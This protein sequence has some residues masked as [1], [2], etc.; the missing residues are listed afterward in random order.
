MRAAAYC[1]YLPGLLLFT[2]PTLVS[3]AEPTPSPPPLSP[4]DRGEGSRSSP[5]APA[6]GARGGGEGVQLFEKKIR[7]ILAEHCYQCH[8]IT[9]QKQRGGLYLDSREGLRKGGDSGPAL[10]P[11]KPEESLLL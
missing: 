6:S 8:S 5:L 1:R 7:P 3:T 2:I 10:V 9:A 11:G 4:P